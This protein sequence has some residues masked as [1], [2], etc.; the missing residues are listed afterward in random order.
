MGVLL[1]LK[2]SY[3][4]ISVTQTILYIAVLTKIRVKEAV[5]AYI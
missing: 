1:E 3:S 4:S 5:K 2:P